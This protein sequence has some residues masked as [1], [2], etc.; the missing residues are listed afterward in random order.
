MNDGI[1]FV[2]SFFNPFDVQKLYIF[3][4]LLW[5]TELNNTKENT[6]ISLI[7]LSLI[8]ETNYFRNLFV[9]NK[10]LSRFQSN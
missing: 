8:F 3:F 5:F 10:F 2:F 4:L 1:S 7:L 6:R 9:S